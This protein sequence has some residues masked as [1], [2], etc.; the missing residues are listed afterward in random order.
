MMNKGAG[1]FIINNIGLVN[2]PSHQEKKNFINMNFDI[3]EF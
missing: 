1:L 3:I 2:E